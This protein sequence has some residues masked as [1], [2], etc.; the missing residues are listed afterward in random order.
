MIFG[1]KILGWI[2]LVVPLLGF[3]GFTFWMMKEAMKDDENLAAFI[4]IMIVLW[5]LG[6]GILGVTYLAE[7]LM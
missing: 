7:Y 2:L 5:V 1:L 4:Y 6:L 3:T